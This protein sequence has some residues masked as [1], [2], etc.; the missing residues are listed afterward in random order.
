MGG[1]LSPV[2]GLMKTVADEVMSSYF[3]MFMFL[4]FVVAVVVQTKSYK[5]SFIPER[6]VYSS[7]CAAVMILE[8]S[9][10]VNDWR[11]I[12]S[13]VYLLQQYV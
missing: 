13:S 1:F 8:V 9:G 11:I 3:N 10:E 2:L 5:V 12:L 7:F 4:L 6:G